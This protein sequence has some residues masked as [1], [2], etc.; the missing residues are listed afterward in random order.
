MRTQSQSRWQQEV[1]LLINIKILKHLIVIIFNNKF[2]III[3]VELLLKGK[4]WE[5]FV[6][7]I[8]E[9]LVKTLNKY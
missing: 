1:L 8:L 3:N 2:L 7:K 5:K 4:I 6:L 9:V